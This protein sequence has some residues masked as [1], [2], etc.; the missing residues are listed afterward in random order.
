MRGVEADGTQD[1]HQVVRE[2]M[3]QPLALLRVPAVARDEADALEIEARQQH[4]VQHA[5]LLV[6][7]L[8]RDL[9]DRA[10]LFGRRHVVGT[11]LGH[12]ERLLVDQSGDA[13]LEEFV[14]VR[15]R[16][17]Q[18]RQPFEQRHVVVLRHVR[19]RAD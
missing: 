8:V 10:Q 1:R 11:A 2:V 4:L 7:Q 19:A 6:E 16:D 9:R 17:A 3:P 12:A 5:V 15:V 14:E 18:E 13:D